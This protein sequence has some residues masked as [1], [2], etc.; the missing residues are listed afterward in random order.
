[1]LV[2]LAVLPA[3]GVTAQQNGTAMSLDELFRLAD[4][5]SRSQKIHTFKVDEAAK[6]VASARDERLPQIDAALSVSYLGNGYVCDRDFTDG[7][8]APIPHYGNN[9]VL[10]ASQI[11]Y[12]GGAVS[13]GIRMAEIAGRIAEEEKQLGRNDLRLMVASY[14][15]EMYK[16][17]NQIR[18][19]DR[20]IALTEEL[21]A[22]VRARY[23]QGTVLE[24]DI[25]RYELQLENYRLAKL[26]LENS[27]HLMN[28]RLNRL[29]GLDDNQTVAIAD[30]ARLALCPDVAPT[31]DWQQ[32]AA[33][34][35]PSVAMSEL[36]I[37][38]SE[39]QERI[40]R[41]ES[42]PKVAL[43]AEEHLDGPVT[44]EIPAL[45]KNFNYWFVGV[46]VSFNIASLY[47][48]KSRTG[49]A[50]TE[51]MRHREEL[52]KTRDDLACAVEDA[53]TRYREAM[54]EKTTLEKNVQLATQNYRTIHLRYTNGLS[55]ATDMLEVSNALLDAEL[56]LAN[57]HADVQFAYYRLKH[58][59]GTI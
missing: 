19:Y 10:T 57:A 33:R 28:F 3:L 59:A 9:F 2:T 31:A 17:D 48:N 25:T 46:G 34:E 49:R 23:E 45:D 11:I 4:E 43:I 53:C 30:T 51:T 22:S 47:K 38:L 5:N 13:G 37:Q 58:T 26:R 54:H 6:A 14:Y 40:V 27:R 56:R 7:M 55:L 16:T 29:V 41:S 36:A 35:A 8:K 39:Q 44:I 21:I 50:R 15:L 42:L 52:E 24:N 32:T 18:V 12:S 20:N 1:M